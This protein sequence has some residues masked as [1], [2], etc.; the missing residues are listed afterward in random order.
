MQPQAIGN[1]LAIAW[2]CLQ[3]PIDCKVR[4]SRLWA[5]RGR[6]KFKNGFFMLENPIPAI[7]VA[8]SCMFE[9]D[10]AQAI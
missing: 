4:L 3:L 2:H 7:F 10:L 5:S 9:Q 6:E 8:R 1:C